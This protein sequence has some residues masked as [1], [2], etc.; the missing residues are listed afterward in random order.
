MNPVL[1]NVVMNTAPELARYAG[2]YDLSPAVRTYGEPQEG[3]PQDAGTLTFSQ[4]AKFSGISTSVML[5]ATLGGYAFDKQITE[6]LSLPEGWGPVVGAALGFTATNAIAGLS[7]GIPASAGYAVGG[8][9]T[10]IPAAVAAYGFK[11]SPRHSGTAYVLTGLALAT[12]LFG[13]VRGVT[14]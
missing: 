9:A 14:K 10:L 1:A 4:A 13:V 6:K 3:P 12:V 8:A 7:Q 5:A 2:L 11:Q